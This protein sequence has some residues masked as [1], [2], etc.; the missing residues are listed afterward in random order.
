M[1]PRFAALHYIRS[2][3]LVDVVSSF[4]FDTLVYGVYYAAAAALSNKVV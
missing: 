4:P 2:W 1:Q 3:L